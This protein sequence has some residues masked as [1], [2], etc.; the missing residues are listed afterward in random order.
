MEPVVSLKARFLQAF[1]SLKLGGIGIDS[2]LQVGFMLHALLG[3]YHP[4]VQE[5]RLDRHPLSEA[6][7]QT[8]VDQCVNFDKDPF[9]SP[10]GKDGKLV[11]NVSANAAGATPL[12]GKNAYK[13]FAAKLFNYHFSRWK[14]AIGENKGKCMFCHDTACNSD[15]K[16]RD[17]PILK[18]LG[19]KLEKRT[20]LDNAGG[21][22]ASRVTAPPAGDASKPAC[23]Q[24]PLWMPPLDRKLFQAPMLPQVSPT[25]MTWGTTM[26]MRGGPAVR[27]TRV[28]GLVNLMQPL[29]RTS[30]LP[31]PVTT[32]APMLEQ[33]RVAT[34][35]HTLGAPTTLLQ[36]WGATTFPQ[37]PLVTLGVS[38]LSTFPRQYLHSSRAPGPTNQT[39]SA[40]GPGLH[41]S[42]Q[43]LEPRTTC[44]L[45]SRLSFP[46]IWLSGSKFAW[47]TI[48]LLQSSGTAL[49][50]SL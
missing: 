47:A 11:Q 25:L 29:L 42:W 48:C 8:V 27:C 45:I 19:F 6:S 21:D 43:T 34:I 24:P 30:T 4:V 44:Y 46:I 41:F 22:A 32:L 9:L 49:P 15:H 2:A 35:L 26:I 14:K 37:L 28:L 5:F 12:D 38:R 13:A 50:S 3:R 16:S 36:L 17:C 33:W 7:L 18:K 1:S 39:I 31:C 20:S 10:V 23:P 40:E